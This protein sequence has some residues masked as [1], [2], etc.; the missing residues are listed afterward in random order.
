MARSTLSTKFF[1]TNVSKFERTFRENYKKENNKPFKGNV[2]YEI[3]IGVIKQKGL[4]EINDVITLIKLGNDIDNKNAE[5]KLDTWLANEENKVRGLV[6]AF[7]DLC[8]DICIDLPINPLFVEEVNN[9][10]DT[11]TQRQNML[12]KLS[13]MVKQFGKVQTAETEVEAVDKNR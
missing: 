10:E 11:I 7:C 12:N 9:L 8:K 1:I 6:G 3:T 4:P 13:E 5:V 2:I